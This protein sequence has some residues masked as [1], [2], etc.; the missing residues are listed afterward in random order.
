MTKN[1]FIEAS[2]RDGQKI[3]RLIRQFYSRQTN[4]DVFVDG[5]AHHGFHTSFARRFFTG[6]VIAV[7]AS[8]KTFVDHLNRQRNLAGD[9]VLCMEIP[10]NVALG[11]RETQGETIEFFYSEE[12]PGR[13]TVNAKIWDTWAKGAVSYNAPIQTAVMEIDDL[14]DF[15]AADRRIDFI[16]LDLEGNEVAALRGGRRTLTTD[17]PNVVM[18]FGL[19]PNNEEEY[20]ETLDRFRY[21]LSEIGYRAIAPWG[22]D[23]TDGMVAG[24]PFWYVFLMPQGDG[25]AAARDLL[26]TVYAESLTE[27]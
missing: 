6:G 1:Q 2:R 12:H 16:K 10:L 5:G 21:F 20:G 7:E 25:M 26:D 22:E 27:N 14:K 23:V 11:F 8:P 9:Q 19:K 13:S 24:Y 15:L 3:E 18:E 4:R 17:R